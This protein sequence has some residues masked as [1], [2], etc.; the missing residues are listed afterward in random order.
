MNIEVEIRGGR[1]ID[2][3]NPIR[4]RPARTNPKTISL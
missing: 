4:R 3:A 1:P 2:N